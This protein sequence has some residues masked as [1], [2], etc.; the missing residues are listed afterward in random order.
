M[1][2]T[3]AVMLIASLAAA[4]CSR[5]NPQE[6]VARAPIDSAQAS[7]PT[8]PLYPPIDPD[9]QD[10]TVFEYSGDADYRSP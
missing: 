10:G 4:A 5:V 6:P 2:P 8:R 1:K 3:L 9:A 7:E